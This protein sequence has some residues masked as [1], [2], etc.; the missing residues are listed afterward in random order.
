[1]R[2]S[3]RPLGGPRG[4]PKKSNVFFTAGTGEYVQ[5][6]ITEKANGGAL[7]DWYLAQSPGVTSSQVTLYT[8]RQDYRALISPD[9]AVH[10]VDFGDRAAVVTYNVG[11]RN[12][13]QY[14]IT[15]QMM[16]QSLKR[17]P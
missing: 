15:F 8:T 13:L 12:Q 3:S 16:V 11:Q 10:Y 9:Q 1:M 4:S 14:K 17:L 6:L 2:S 7:L 5:V